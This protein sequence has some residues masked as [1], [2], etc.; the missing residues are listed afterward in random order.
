ML[1][2]V[3]LLLLSVLPPYCHLFLT[4]FLP[5]KLNLEHLQHGDQ[6]PF[7]WKFCSVSVSNKYCL[8]TMFSLHHNAVCSLVSLE[9]IKHGANVLDTFGHN[10]CWWV[11]FS[12]IHLFKANVFGLLQSD[13][14]QKLVTWYFSKLDLWCQWFFVQQLLMA[15]LTSLSTCHLLS[16]VAFRAL[17]KGVDEVPFQGRFVGAFNSCAAV[18]RRKQTASESSGEWGVGCK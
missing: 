10:T 2:A 17:L 5:L 15:I 11:S 13:L 16:T 4:I 7:I 3:V 6:L 1:L 12:L 14:E 9:P 18:Q 8:W